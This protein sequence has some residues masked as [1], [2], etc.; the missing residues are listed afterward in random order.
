MGAAGLG[1]TSRGGHGRAPAGL[2]TTSRAAEDETRPAG[3]ARTAEDARPGTGTHAR[4]GTAAVAR[5]RRRGPRRGR[6]V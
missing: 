2:G 1:T 4:P 3:D 5:A 6:V